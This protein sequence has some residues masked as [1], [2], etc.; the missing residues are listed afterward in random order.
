MTMPPNP[1]S[2][3]PPD[4]LAYDLLPA[5]S[6]LSLASMILGIIGLVTSCFGIG[7]LIGLVGLILG[8]IAFV[9]INKDPR[10]H[11]GMGFAI[12]G[13]ATGSVALIALPILLAILFPG[14]SRSREISNRAFCAA[15]LRG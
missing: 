9:R 7:I 11:S 5:R 14:L 1:P 4:T 6:G 3:A 13:I 15:N 8:I 12:A 2:P 10:V